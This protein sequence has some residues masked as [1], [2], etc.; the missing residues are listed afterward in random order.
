METK[1][2]IKEVNQHISDALEQWSTTMLVADA[3]EWS[4]H[5]NYNKND[6]LNAM[7]ICSHVLQNIAIKSGHIKNEKDAYEKSSIFRKAIKDFCGLDPKD[8]VEQNK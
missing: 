5:L 1:E 8:L 7:L 2:Q 6:A 3:D 4:F